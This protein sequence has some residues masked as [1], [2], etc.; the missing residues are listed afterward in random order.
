MG[1][2]FFSRCHKLY[3]TICPPPHFRGWLCIANSPPPW[4]VSLKNKYT[5][6]ISYKHLSQI[7]ICYC[8]H[9][10]RLGIYKR[11]K[12]YNIAFLNLV[13]EFAR[14]ISMVLTIIIADI[15]SLFWQAICLHTCGE[16]FMNY[17]KIE[18]F[19]TLLLKNIIIPVV[20]L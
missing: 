19:R 14:T 10:F 8:F 7:I 18:I 20:A 3:F 4:V 12:M 16:I 2:F 9:S 15:F 5:L 11:K 1:L 17:Y 6:T 13:L